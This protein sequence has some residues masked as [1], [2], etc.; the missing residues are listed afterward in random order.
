VPTLS[1]RELKLNLGCGQA[2]L[3]GYVNVD[4][5]ALPGVDIVA[6]IEDVPVA[7]DSVAE[8]YSAHLLEHVPQEA[9]RRQ[10]LPYWRSLLRPDGLLRAVVPDG[11]AMIAGVA[12]GSYPFDDFRRDLF[13]AQENESDYHHNLLTPDS[14]RALLLEAGFTDIA[15]STRGRTDGRR[16]EFEI[17][18][19]KPSSDPAA[20][21]RPR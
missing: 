2:P 14:L 6:P 12:E 3:S 15:V 4:R 9:L 20:T 16:F 18:A 10:L 11:S 17:V 5:R 21:Q 19:R 7:P 13:G 1:G 8:I